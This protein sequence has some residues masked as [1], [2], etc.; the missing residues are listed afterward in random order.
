MIEAIKQQFNPSM[1]DEE[2]LNRAREFLQVLCLKIMHDKGRLDNVAFVGGTALRLLFGMRRFSEDLD[3]SITT[4]RKY[5][6]PALCAELEREFGLMGLPAQAKPNHE[7]AVHNTM[8]TFTGLLKAIGLSPLKGQKFSIKLEI[9]SSPPAGWNIEQSVIN[10]TYI[11]AISHHNLASLFAGKLHAC[12][13]RPYTKGR[14]IYDLIW[15]LGKKVKPNFRMLNNAIEQTQGK[16]PGITDKNFK[17]Y[18]VA[19]VK[20]IDFPAARRDVERFLEDKTE[21]SLFDAKLLTSQAK[22]WEAR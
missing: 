3:F 22:K 17:E 2:K 4:G 21:L 7:K 16:S 10:Q 18:L 15:Y 20:K 9:D 12:F 1:A 19:A 14:D 6:F 11:F 13:Y 5:D 8:L